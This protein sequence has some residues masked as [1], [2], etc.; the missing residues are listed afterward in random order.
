MDALD[1]LIFSEQPLPR[2][3]NQPLEGL[4]TTVAALTPATD[5]N[6]SN[7]ANSLSSASGDIPRIK[8]CCHSPSITQLSSLCRH[9]PPASS[10]V[11]PVQCKP[12][13]LSV[14]K[15][16]SRDLRVT[17]CADIRAR[18]A[19]LAEEELLQRFRR[20]TADHQVLRFGNVARKLFAADD[21]TLTR[22]LLTH[23]KE[24]ELMIREHCEKPH[25][26]PVCVD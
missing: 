6:C 13:M 9:T 21:N 23:Q 8:H 14:V 1:H 4:S 15:A 20:Q 10:V 11:S 25:D 2:D 16:S 18:N 24:F 17:D 26:R 3:L 7:S 19:L 22:L 5:A 12:D